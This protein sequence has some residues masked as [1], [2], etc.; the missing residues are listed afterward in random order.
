MPSANAKHQLTASLPLQV[1]VYYN[2]IVSVVYF[3]F[4][5]VGVYIKVNNSYVN[6]EA[7]EVSWK[8]NVLCL[9]HFSKLRLIT[10]VPLSLSLSF[11]LF[12]FSL[13]L[14][15]SSLSLFSL[16]SSLF[17]LSLFLSFSLSLFLSFSLSLF[18]SFSLSLFLFLCFSSFCFHL[19]FVF[20]H[21]LKFFVSTL[22]TLGTQ[23]KRFHSYQRL[24]CQQSFLKY[25]SCYTWATGSEQKQSDSAMR[26]H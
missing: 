22:V 24:C 7:F 4:T 9:F 6:I 14:S 15:L 5:G 20:G 10:N 23:T 8:K 11:S 18:L 2:A 1:M 3:L 21:C 12:S 17:S 13:S 19:L 26:Y 25:L 16:L